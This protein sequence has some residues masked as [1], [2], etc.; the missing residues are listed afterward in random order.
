LGSDRPDPWW[1]IPEDERDRRGALTGDTCIIDDEEFFIRGVI[2]IPV[3]GHADPFGFGVWVSQKKENFYTYLKS[4]DSAEIGPFFGWLCT[5][6]WYYEEDSTHLKSMAH[7]RAGNM[8]PTIELEPTD[9]PL[10]V[11]QRNGISQER[12]WEIVHF[13]MNLDAERTRSAISQSDDRVGLSKAKHHAAVE[14]DQ[15][16][17]QDDWPFDQPRNRAVFTLRQIVD[18]LEPVLQVTHDLDD[19]AWQFLGLGDAQI[20]DLVIVGFEEIVGRDCS[21]RELADLPAGWH[22]WRRYVADPWTREL[23]P[24]ADDD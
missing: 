23:N 10:A 4:F 12:A 13:Y 1:D 11:D 8:R 18:G 20:E 19:D 16:E 22:A 9:H 17:N 6:V 24:S 5:R 7:F 2:E 14:R 21:L 15:Q 3:H